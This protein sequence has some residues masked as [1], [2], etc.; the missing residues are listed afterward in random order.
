M[1]KLLDVVC[2]DTRAH[3][4]AY[5]RRSKRIDLTPTRAQEGLN[6]FLL[7]QDVQSCL[8]AMGTYGG[9]WGPWVDV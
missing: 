9:W 3:H 7:G 8:T 4:G 1:G 6:G 2:F 5:V